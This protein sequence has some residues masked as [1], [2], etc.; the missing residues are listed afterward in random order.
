MCP[1]CLASAAPVIAGAAS[2]GAALALVVGKLR[3]NGGQREKAMETIA[4]KSP[5][6]VSR[7]EWLEARKALLV[8]EKELTRRRDELT[9]Q[10]REL[11]WVKVEKSYVFDTAEGKKSLAELFG[12]K[13]QLLVYHFMFGPDWEE[14]CPSCSFLSDHIDGANWHLP[15]RDVRLLAVSRAPL[16]KIEKFKKR[17][18][19]RF[20]WVSSFG[21]DFNFDYGVSFPKEDVA[22]DR[23]NYNYTVSTA[24]GSE[25]L[26]GLSAFYKDT[27]GGVFDT[28][29]TY[30]R[31]CDMLVGAYNFL[32][33]AP[34]G[35]DEDGMDFTMRWVRHHDR[36][37]DERPRSAAK[38]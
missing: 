10:R 34:K 12:D 2:G 6:V 25:D 15:E 4:I 17:M 31:G 24:Y 16:A 9:R 32:D 28:Y 22:N 14:G 19:W 20:D 33:L 1:L 26:H 35:R 13:S 5:K 37:G 29:S 7:E 3:K 38:S 27:A 23:V 30:G 18:G 21:S 8:Q 36:Y 11:P